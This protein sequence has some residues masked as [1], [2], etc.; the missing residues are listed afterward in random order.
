MTVIAEEEN[1]GAVPE[2]TDVI[3]ESITAL[4]DMHKKQKVYLE[5]C[6]D[7][8]A[9]K[10]ESLKAAIA[11]LTAKWNEENAA[12]VKV[13]EDAKAAL[14]TIEMN[15]RAEAIEFYNETGL[16]T[17]NENVGVQIRKSFEYSMADAVKWAEVNAPVMIIKSVD[18]KPFETLAETQD[19][20]FIKKVE[21][22]SA[23]LKGI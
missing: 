2:K 16:K 8:V 18:K 7:V 11:E 1:E 4:L 5:I 10:Q 23:V 20:D 19:L 13:Y 3:S 22:V 12:D 9:E 6:R 21:K 17:F 14:D 15:L